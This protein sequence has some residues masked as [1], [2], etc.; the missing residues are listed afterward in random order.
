MEYVGIHEYYT[1]SGYGLTWVGSGVAT[2]GITVVMSTMDR[3]LIQKWG[4]CQ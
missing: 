1:L 4:Q 3:D 2:I